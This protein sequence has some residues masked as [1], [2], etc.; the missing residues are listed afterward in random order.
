[1]IMKKVKMFS[2]INIQKLYKGNSDWTHFLFKL[3]SEKFIK[4]EK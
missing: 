3:R 1:M 2:S 4:N